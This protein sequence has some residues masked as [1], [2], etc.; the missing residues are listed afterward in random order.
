[1]QIKINGKPEDVQAQT[2]LELLQS[3]DIEPQ[4]VSVEQNAQIVEREAY[5]STAIKENDVL[6]FLFFMGGG[7]REHR[8]NRYLSQGM[9]PIFLS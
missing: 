5:A 6:E 2:I 9:T 1:M 4:M 7:G 3:K 8:Q